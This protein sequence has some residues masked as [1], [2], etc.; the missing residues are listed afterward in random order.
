MHS[1]L[2]T[3]DRT[4]NQSE[5]PLGFQNHEKNGWNILVVQIP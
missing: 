1:T 2:N 3:L 5:N 4:W